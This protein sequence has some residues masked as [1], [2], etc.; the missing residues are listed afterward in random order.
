MEQNESAQRSTGPGATPF[1]Q[2]YFHGTKAELKICL[3]Y[4][5]DAADERSS[6]DLGG[7]RIIKKK[8]RE[9]VGCRSEM[10]KNRNTS[11]ARELVDHINQD[12]E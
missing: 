11:I 8:N 3:L 10:I 4:T 5:S 9:E 6:V 2:T 7:R 12:Q 1:V